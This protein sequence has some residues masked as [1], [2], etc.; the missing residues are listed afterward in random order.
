MSFRAR[1][2]GCP[3]C[4]DD[5]RIDITGW[6][7]VAGTWTV[8]GDNLET[9]SSSGLAVTTN[10]HP[11]AKSTHVVIVH[12][13]GNSDGDILRVVVAYADANN[14]LY[15]ELEVGTT[16]GILRL[17][18]VTGGSTFQLGVDVSVTGLK[19]GELH[20][21]RVCYDGEAL[22]AI[23]PDRATY[24]QSVSVTGTRVGVATGAIDTLATF[25]DFRWYIHYDDGGYYGEPNNCPSCRAWC[26]NCLN[27]ENPLAF[28]VVLAGLVNDG[29]PCQDYNGTHIL[30]ISDPAS[31]C[32]YLKVLPYSINYSAAPELQFS[33]SASWINL[34][35]VYSNPF[36]SGS[37]DWRWIVTNPDCMNLEDAD[38]PYLETT[39]AAYCDA[40]ASTCKVTSL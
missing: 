33:V 14:Y 24:W 19:I 9:A 30:Q 4:D 12:I 2:P 28:K 22:K 27:N 16:N 34:A 38:I 8:D 3:C 18:Q 15:A 40:A 5:C 36:E 13:K 1:Q 10:A 11:E 25:T 39:G 35:W 26:Q 20:V 7:Q 6:N 31:S 37:I 32:S 21:V 23:L 29:A 17:F